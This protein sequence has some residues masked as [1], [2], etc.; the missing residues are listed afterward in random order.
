MIL[1]SEVPAEFR[2]K[3]PYTS[4]N[5]KTSFFYTFEEENTGSFELW[6]NKDMNMEKGKLYT[7]S[8]NLHFYNGDRRVD[9]VEVLPYGK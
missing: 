5:G 1:I 6:S 8:F 9:L 3:R 7:L 2:I 4:N